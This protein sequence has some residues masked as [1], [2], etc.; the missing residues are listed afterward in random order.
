[1]TEDNK[2]QFQFRLEFDK[3]DK[4]YAN[5]LLN[6]AD[7]YKKTYGDMKIA[8]ISVNG[9]KPTMY[10]EEIISNVVTLDDFFSS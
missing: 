8:M 1:M 5:K 4:Q 9:L 7:V 3:T 2:I 6:K 10:S